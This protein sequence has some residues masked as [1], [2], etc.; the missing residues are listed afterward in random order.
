MF[1]YRVLLGL[2]ALIS[3][4]AADQVTLEV[5]INGLEGELLDNA[6]A[7]LSLELYRKESNLSELRIQRLHRKAKDEI[8][9]ALQPYGYYL[10]VIRAQLTRDKQHWL[11]R[12]DIDPGQPTRWQHIDIVLIGAGNQNPLLQRSVEQSGIYPGNAINHSQYDAFKKSLLQTAQ[13]NGYLDAR[14]RESRLIIQEDRLHADVILEFDTGVQ[15]TLG[16]VTFEG[17]SLPPDMLRD[18]IPFKTGAVFSYARLQKL[19]RALENS[20]YFANVEVIPEQA[21]AIDQQIPV[22]VQLTPHP[23]NR[24][25]FGVGFGTDTGPRTRIGW[26]NRQ[27]NRFGHKAEADYRISEI[28]TS[29]NALYRIPLK[30]AQTDFLQFDTS[31]G[32]EETDSSESRFESLGVKF[33]FLHAVWRKTLSLTHRQEDF[34]AG[35]TSGDTVLLI[36]AISFSRI[37]GGDRLIVDKGARVELDL[38]GASTD[39][40]SEATFMQATLDSK[41]IHSPWENGRVLLRG[42]VGAT[43]TPE[44]DKLP[45]S[46]RFYAGGDQ[47]VRGYDYESLGPKDA[48]GE[49]IGAPFLLVGSV[50]YEHLIKG[51]WRGALFY[52]VGNAIEHF[53]DPLE[54]GVGVG[55]RYQSPIGLIRLDIANAISEP[56]NPWRL[57][58]TIGPDL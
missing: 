30:R 19:Q 45:P 43:H 34:E 2:L 9:L 40:F 52:D 57:H 46:I 42:T 41:L 7:L 58:L 5:Q 51:N 23:P 22:R 53:N 36:P 3:V 16:E 33:S 48:S 10:P 25:L 44:F 56:D 12:Y 29:F 4:A 54:Q 24:Y 37:W 17:T 32:R 11:A 27:L 28:K 21:Q 31:I 26:E 20:D 8:S 6:R 18:Y 55:I 35:L 38:S 39:L 49:V 50:E 1:F 13:A 15:Y 47:S 14:F